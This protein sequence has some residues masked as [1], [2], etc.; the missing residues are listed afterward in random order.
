MAGKKTATEVYRKSLP[1]ELEVRLKALWSKLEHLI[2]WC[3]SAASWTERFCS[4]AR[5]YREAF[6]WE[7]M[8]KMVDDYLRDH[9]GA[10]PEE[11]LTDS[12]VATQCSP[13]SGDSD[14]LH[15]FRSVWQE[16][17]DRSGDD[18][19]AFIR[20]DLELAAQEGTYDAVAALYAADYH[21]WE[22][23]EDSPT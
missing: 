17:L 23:G 11:V 2:D 4:E 6:Y 20:E 22:E 14:R 16:V 13:S 19:K 10:I 21:R 5:P 8:A 7:A 15:H 1:D 18:V 12:L 9:Q 3:D